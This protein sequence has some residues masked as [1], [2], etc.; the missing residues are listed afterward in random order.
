MKTILL[1]CLLMFLTAC[2]GNHS[3]VFQ[4]QTAVDQGTGLVWAKNANLPGK[5]IPWKA[6]DNVYYFIQKLNSDNF[7][8]YADWRVPTK[9]E[10]DE[11]MAYAM[12]LGY[13]KNKRETWPFQKLRM[14]GFIDV[15]DYDYWTSTRRSPEEIWVADLASGRL[16]PKSEAKPYCLW[17]VRG[18]DPAK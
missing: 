11:L 8:G 5:P 17:P 14:L 1:V 15:R 3:F 4:D 13:D 12:T 7:A 18:G 10:M 16:Q 9:E 2:A 6:D